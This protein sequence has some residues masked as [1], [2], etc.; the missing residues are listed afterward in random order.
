MAVIVFQEE[1]EVLPRLTALGVTKSELLDVVRAAVGARRDATPFHPASAGG[2]Y[3][4]I[5]GTRRLRAIYVPQ[6]WEIDRTDNIESIFSPGIG[7][8]IIYQSA[9]R[10]GDPLRD[11]LA[12][13]RKGAG[14]ARAV[15]LAQGELWPEIRTTELRKV[16]AA[17]WYLFVYADGDDVRAELSFPISIADDQFCGFNERII[18]VQNGEWLG[19]DITPEDADLLDFEVSVTRKD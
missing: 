11:P 9:G 6:G 14:S 18:L 15:E 12:V 19:I 2:L 3:A 17:S 16:N 4:W 7:I 5:E 1:F 10:A 8:K 13:S